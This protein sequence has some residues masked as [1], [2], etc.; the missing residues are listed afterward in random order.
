MWTDGERR[1]TIVELLIPRTLSS[2]VLMLMSRRFSLNRRVTPKWLT[3]MLTLC[4]PAG[5]DD[6]VNACLKTK[7]N[8]GLVIVEGNAMRAL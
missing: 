7:R 6:M 8:L 4:A 1:E 5:G 2:K 3:L